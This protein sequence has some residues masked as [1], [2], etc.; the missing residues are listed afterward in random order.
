MS[1]AV[2]CFDV[3]DC[4]EIGGQRRLPS[5]SGPVTIQ[6]IRT[7]AAPPDGDICGIVGNW[8]NL[9]GLIPDWREFLQFLLPPIPSSGPKAFWL[10]WVRAQYPGYRHYVMVGNDPRTHATRPAYWDQQWPGTLPIVHVPGDHLLSDDYR[11]AQEAGFEFIRED[12]WARGVRVGQVPPRDP[13]KP[14]YQ[15]PKDMRPPME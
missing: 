10:A 12:D 13:S 7:E 15:F 11:A 6:S 8:I 1:D 2:Y 5:T 4:L 3:D 14:F 9:P